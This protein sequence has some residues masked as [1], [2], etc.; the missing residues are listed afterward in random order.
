MLLLCLLVLPLSALGTPA[1]K[2]GGAVSKVNDQGRS[3]VEMH[4]AFIGGVP[5]TIS[6]KLW[7]PT[8]R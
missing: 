3:F 4:K 6:L 5:G 2:I 8:T 1:Q 7:L